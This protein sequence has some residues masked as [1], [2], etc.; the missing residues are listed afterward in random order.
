MLD[1]L[2][3]LAAVEGPAQKDSI[4]QLGYFSDPRAGDALA[5]LLEKVKPDLR[6]VVVAAMIR[7][8]A[9]PPLDQIKKYIR[10]PEITKAVYERSAR[11]ANDPATGEPPKPYSRGLSGLDYVAYLR[12]C[13]PLVKPEQVEH[14]MYAVWQVN[15][16]ETIPVLVELLDDKSPEVRRWAV[17]DLQHVVNQDSRVPTAAEFALRGETE[18]A[19][20]KR[21]WAKNEKDVLQRL[22]TRREENGVPHTQPLRLK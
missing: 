12:E 20:W 15:R 9:P 17:G 1:E 13:L 19:D 11:L 22:R 6:P 3:A 21:W 18:V 2:L 7:S 8:D 5:A 16:R 10:E 4:Q 14:V